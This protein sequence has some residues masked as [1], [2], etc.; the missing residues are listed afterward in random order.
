MTKISDDLRQQ[1]KERAQNYCEYC[2][3]PGQLHPLTVD[4][5]KPVTLGGE[6]EFNNLAWCCSGCNSRKSKKT[7][8]VDPDTGKRVA[9][10]NPRQQV[11]QEHFEWSSNFICVIGTINC[12][13]ATVQALGMNREDLVRI[14]KTLK[15]H[16]LHPPNLK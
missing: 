12:G 14:R 15:A 5:I 6:N 4:H 1:V 7:H 3:Y 11:W 13:R 16:G 10:F 8:S 2:R 9:L